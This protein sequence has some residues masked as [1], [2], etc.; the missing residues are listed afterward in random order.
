M[1]FVAAQ[2]IKYAQWRVNGRNCRRIGYHLRFTSTVIAFFNPVLISITLMFE[3][4]FGHEIGW[5]MTFAVN[6][7]KA[8]PTPT[9]SPSYPV[10]AL[11][12][13]WRQPVGFPFGAQC[14]E[15]YGR[16]CSRHLNP[17]LGLSHIAL[18]KPWFSSVQY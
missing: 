18:A 2:F 17:G 1:E 15:W 13:C 9:E 6:K 16:L 3:E 8:C 12:R 7:N 11:L 4:K 14:M 5:W 10:R